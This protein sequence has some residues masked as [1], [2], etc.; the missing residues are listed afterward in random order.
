MIYFRFELETIA[1]ERSRVF[2]GID[3]AQD[4]A[5]ALGSCGN[6]SRRRGSQRG[7]LLK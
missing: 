3:S 5:K 2:K 1:G 4:L 7:N 6:G